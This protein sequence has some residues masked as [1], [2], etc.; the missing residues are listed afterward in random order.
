MSMIGVIGGMG[1]AATNDLCTRITAATPAKRDQDHLEVI[2]FNNPNVPDRTAAILTGSEDPLPAM[3][4]TAQVLEKAGASFLVMPCNTAH[5]YHA[6]LQE[7]LSTPLVHMIEETAAAARKQVPDA[8]YAGLLATSGT[9]GAGIY[10]DP[11]KK[12]GFD[13]IASTSNNQETL[14]MEAIYAIKAG[15]SERPRQLLLEA[16]RHLI[17]AGAQLLI[18]GCTEIPLVLEDGMAS[19]PII[20]PTQILAEVAVVRAIGT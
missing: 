8:R 15:E 3:L 6:Q 18:A 2:T 5:H 9:I 13:I 20:N 12:Q 7:Q 11:F 4:R 19:V 1:P 10:V 17:D 16:G 14:V